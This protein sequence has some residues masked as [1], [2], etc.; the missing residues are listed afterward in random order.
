MKQW[1]KRLSIKQKLM[2]LCFVTTSLAI[3]LTT[4]VV[5]VLQAR[6]MRAQ[7]GRNISNFADTTASLNA[8]ALSLQQIV[9]LNDSALEGMSAAPNILYAGIYSS[10]GTLVSRYSATTG[11]K[12]LPIRPPP[13]GLEFFDTE[14]VAV[15]P[16]TLAGERIGTILITAS[17]ASV[18]ERLIAFTL[19]S[20]GVGGLVIVLT[21]LLASRLQQIVSDPVARLVGTMRRIGQERD[22]GIRAQKGANDELGLLVDGFNEMLAEVQR[23]DEVLQNAQADLEKRVLDRTTELRRKVALLETKETELKKAKDHAEEANQAKSSFLANMSH[24]I[25]TPMNGV[26]GMTSLLLDTPLTATQREF[27]QTVSSS[28]EALLTIINDILDFSKIEA[29]KLE[30][31]I[32]DFDLR[33][34]V[35]GTLDVV[36]QRAQAKGLEFACLIPTDLPTRLRGDPGRLRQVLL[37]MLSNAIKFTQQGEVFLKLSLVREQGGETVIRFDVKDTGIGISP[38]V[39]KK[40]FQPFTQAD[41]ST[42]RKFGGTG[43]GLVI[44]RE[45]IHIMGGEVH[46]ESTP[47]LGTTFWFTVRFEKQLNRNSIATERWLRPALPVLV[48]D[49]NDTNRRIFKSY[50]EAWRCVPTCVESAALGLQALKAADK[51]GTPFPVAILDMQMPEMDGLQLAR[52]IRS[53]P[54]IRQPA[55]IMA[56]SFGSQLAS[57]AHDAGI[58][59]WLSKPVKQSALFQGIA[60]ALSVPETMTPLTEPALPSDKPV[61]K[62]SSNSTYHLRRG[63]TGAKPKILLAEDNIVNQKVASRFFAKL[64][65]Q[66]DITAN[67]AEVLALLEKQEFDLIFMDC[68]M[69]DLDGYETTRRIREIGLQPGREYYR[70]VRIIAMTAHAMQG[71]RQKCL[72][73][74]MNDYLAKPVDMKNLKEAISRNLTAIAVQPPG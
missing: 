5:N 19:A 71:D 52:A 43:L 40:L 34:A 63:P 31:E 4:V 74:G 13:D 47:G 66:I 68:Q 55:M 23:R 32:L 8:A 3:T 56:S 35:E 62:P 48:V 26:I 67:G 53:D 49:D 46:A 20:A 54:M 12:P 42:T 39:I 70:D 37:N 28:A 2:L 44:S 22:Y 16:I 59:V 18:N 30:L 41:S 72:D 69:P 57:S 1:I 24:E 29:R 14:L 38:D 17:T 60:E 50:L 36:A 64:G 65:H 61:S 58:Q 21:M 11:G 15:K 51:A 27:A 9:Q 7:L 73:A 10:D 33:E 25:R 6:E 45:L